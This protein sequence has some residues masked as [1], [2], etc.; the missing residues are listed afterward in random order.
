MKNVQLLLEYDGTEYCGWQVQ[1]NGLSIQQVL[2]EA[3]ERQTGETIR[4]TGSGRTDGG[5]HAYGQVANFFTQSTIPTKNIPFALN[6][7][8]P[9]DIRVLDAQE[10]EETFHSRF[11]A[12][13]KIYEYRILN[14]TH[15]S[16]LRRNR[17][18]HIQTPLDVEAMIKG[19]SYFTGTHN[20]TG[21]SSAKSTSVDKVRTLYSLEL[22]RQNDEIVFWVHGNGFLYNMVRIMVGTL[23]EVGLGKRP[24]EE[25]EW[26]LKAGDRTKSGITAPPQGLYL[27]KVIY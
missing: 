14:N 5:V 1:T 16:G 18:W 10:R 20:F 12:K 13:S 22:E 21:F 7:Q 15:G 26:L 17:V 23:A 25:I 6:T 27:K 19:K 4:I 2:M 11:S 24:P 8:L 3:W 9:K